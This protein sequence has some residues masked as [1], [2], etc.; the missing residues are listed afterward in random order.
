MKHTLILILTL[1]TIGEAHACRHRRVRYRPVRVISP[2]PKITQPVPRTEKEP[3]LSRVLYVT[4]EG[5]EFKAS[6]GSKIIYLHIEGK[7]SD[8]YLLPSYVTQGQRAQAM[9][10]QEE[11]EKAWTAGDPEVWKF[12]YSKLKIRPGGK[13]THKEGHTVLEEPK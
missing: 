11:I 3:V 13:L 12:D 9:R 1:V 7:D 8:T 4:R 2:I 6:D 5:E 10:K